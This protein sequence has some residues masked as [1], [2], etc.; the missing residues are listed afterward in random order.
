[1]TVVSIVFKY[2]VFSYEYYELNYELSCV[3]TYTHML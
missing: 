2:C 1:V 3:L